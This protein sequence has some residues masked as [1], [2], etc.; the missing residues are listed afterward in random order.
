MRNLQFIFVI[1]GTLIP[2]YCF[3]WN[4]LDYEDYCCTNDVPFE[5]NNGSFRDTAD[6][7][8]HFPNY[9]SVQDQVVS[10]A[11]YWND[12]GSQMTLVRSSDVSTCK[13]NHDI[14]M[15]PRDDPDLQGSVG[16]THRSLGSCVLYGGCAA[17]G[18]QSYY[19]LLRGNDETY[20]YYPANWRTYYGDSGTNF[21]N[22]LL[23]EFGH[24]LG[25]GHNFSEY[26]AIAMSYGVS[27]GS[28]P[29]YNIQSVTEDD[30]F[31]LESAHGRNSEVLRFKSAKLGD[32]GL[33]NFSASEQQET[34][35]N[36]KTFGM[37]AI[38]INPDT[39]TSRDFDFAVA[40][41]RSS[42]RAVGYEL[43]KMNSLDSHTV[44][45]GPTHFAGYTSW[46]GPSI[47]VNNSGVVAIAYRFEKENPS[48]ND[49]VE[50]NRNSMI[51]LRVSNAART[52]FYDVEPSTC[53]DGR[54]RTINTPM[55]TYNWGAQRWLIAFTENATS[56][57]AIGNMHSVSVLV[58]DD[59]TGLTW[60]RPP[61]RTG[62]HSFWAP[63]AIT[64]D[65]FWGFGK[66]LLV[67]QNWDRTDG[68]M[69]RTY[70]TVIEI[71]NNATSG[72]ALTSG[73][74]FEWGA[75]GFG[76]LGLAGSNYGWI[77]T[78]LNTPAADYDD[79]T[80][81]YK[82]WA[83]GLTGAWTSQSNWTGTQSEKGYGVACNYFGSVDEVWCRFVWAK[84]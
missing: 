42:D 28:A 4:L 77:M 3:A 53:A 81:S 84:E 62:Y 59:S 66:C 43:I 80:W 2:A 69:A 8:A 36:Q 14:C 37:P 73:G 23:H 5:I 31:G 79:M 34:T 24:V 22:I 55:I 39:S 74:S 67:Y 78:R 75:S 82:N 76:H 48:I 72:L 27:R 13:T 6:E 15:V 60:S 26:N 63:P 70:Q 32:T 35:T 45:E 30:S 65:S 54:C 9:Y 64:C 83:Q 57:D 61:L 33:T 46:Q 40:W 71:D 10:A 52:A 50:L 29:G 68:W 56:D 7:L 25:L 38:A 51:R 41:T 58:S 18:T 19:I 17:L 16:I 11:N 44:V 1:I 20:P 12:A 21:T 49:L 47:A